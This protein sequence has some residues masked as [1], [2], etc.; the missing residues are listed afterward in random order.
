[1]CQIKKG[2]MA[3]EKLRDL[4]LEVADMLVPGS[5]ANGVVVQDE[6]YFSM[7]IHVAGEI[8][9][10]NTTKGGLLC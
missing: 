8:I 9:C 3:P 4:V 10:L 5:D 2:A 7:T 6:N 1:M